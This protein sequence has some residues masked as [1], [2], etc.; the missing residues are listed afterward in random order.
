MTCLAAVL[1][2]WLAV[3][4]IV[5]LWRRPHF[6]NDPHEQFLRAQTLEREGRPAEALASVDRAIAKDPRNAGYVV[7]EGYRYLDLGDSSAAE[8][9][10]RRA[11]TIEPANV[12]ARLGLA[13]ALARQHRVD[14]AMAQLQALPSD[15]LNSNQLKR[16]S[17]LFDMLDAP[18]PALEDLSMALKTAPNDPEL[19]RQATQLAQRLQ[20]WSLTASFAFRLS[21]ATPD[22]AVRQ[23]AL[24]RRAA[25]LEKSGQL[26][27]AYGTYQQT[28]NPSDLEARAWLAM[29]LK[30][31]GDASQL[32]QKLV[33][34][35]PSEPGFRRSLAFALQ[36]AGRT[37]DA[38]RVFGSLVAGG[39][40]DVATRQAYAW[41]LNTQHRYAEAWA[42]I[43][44]LPRP[45]DD[46]ELLELQTRTAIWAGRLPDAVNLIPALIA[47][48]PQDAELW[49]QLGESWHRLG[50]EAAA[51]EALRAY[52]RFR[53]QDWKARRRLADILGANGSVEEAIH[54]YAELVAADPNNGELWRSLGL[55]QETAGQLDS[56]T[57]SYAR[58]VE[59]LHS[60]EP[61]LYLRL[62]RVSRWS[63]HPREAIAWYRKYLASVADSSL[64]RPAEGELALSLFEAG[65]P[66]A[67]A[68]WFR[69]GVTLD[70]EELITAARAIS[71]SGATGAPLEAAQY[72]EAL[73]ARRGL[74]REQEVWLA[75]LYRASAQP[76]RALAVYERADARGSQPD[77]RVSE[78]IADLRF[79]TGDFAGAMQALRDLVRTPGVDLKMARA[80][81]RAGLRAE[82]L[83]AYD[84]YVRAHP[85][86]TD[87]TLEAARYYA[88]AGRAQE[89][90]ANYLQVV[91]DRGAGDLR[92]EIARAYLATEHPAEAEAWARQAVAAGENGADARLVL[93]QSL[94]LLGKDREARAVLNG[95]VAASAGQNN[96][97]EWQG[98]VASALDR[99]LEAYRAFTRAISAD[100]SR[101]GTL[102]VLRGTAAQKRGDYGQADRDFAAAVVNGAPAADVDNARK[103]L[104]VATVPLVSAPTW[105]I[106]DNN[107]LRMLQSGAEVVWFLPSKSASL[108]LEASTGTISQRDFSSNVTAVTFSVAQLFPAPELRLD[109]AAGLRQYTRGSDLVTWRAS[110]FYFFPNDATAGAT[111]SRQPLLDLNGLPELRHFNRVLDV[112]AIGPGFHTESVSGFFDA[113]ISGNSRIR[114]ESGFEKLQDDNSRAFLYLHYQIPISTRAD[115]WFVVRPNGFFEMFREKLGAYFSPRRHLTLGT[116]LHL[117]KRNSRW[118]IESEINPQLLFTDGATGFGGHGLLNLSR[119]VGQASV[120][121]GVF[122]FYD[123]LY[124][125]VQWRAAG[126]VT[127][128]LGR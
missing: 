62:A 16:R 22:P 41:L 84:S 109:F 102:L 107:H 46:S 11:L 123:G 97:F 65:D 74:S 77:P 7:F 42:V 50:N 100:E 87:A 92:V 13:T 89:A 51:V 93:A 101:A 80:A 47:R 64:R 105:V 25:A 58:A 43:E 56:A 40:A 39:A 66:E 26:A 30:R 113:L 55:L 24:E 99:Q 117:I 1:V 52:V 27:E 57:S 4:I 8:Q 111:F 3:V 122:V 94:H 75:D 37:G 86:D 17:Q 85:A 44:P 128:P 34:E 83:S 31:Y 6:W 124:D 79:E 96:A 28:S 91:R 103:G 78:A 15:V 14:E 125:H 48:R 82:A 112:G 68:A 98:Y 21:E 88:S 116:M 115:Q 29:R 71:A 104:H 81:A 54:Q 2:L 108:S 73:R 20:D 67:S 38:A 59:R 121:A 53:S 32:Y 45:S 110:G 118:E 119:K 70:E 5:V 35:H 23:W 10:F 106:G 63:A 69:T 61:G 9:S 12:E 60:P 90:I 114:A 127:L 19:L 49:Q 76:Y 120:G 18:Q 126:R 72:L 33:D 95:L 36:A